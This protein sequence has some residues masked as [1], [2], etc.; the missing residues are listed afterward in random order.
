MSEGLTAQLAIKVVGIWFPISAFVA[1]GF[2]HIPA[3]MFMIPLGLLAG[4]DVTVLEMLYKNFL[5]TTLGNAIAGSLIV[6]GGYSYAFGR[7]GNNNASPLPM[8]RIS[9][10]DLEDYKPKGGYDPE[11]QM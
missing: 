10:E 7:L 6:A 11:V 1:I 8:S 9:R 3:N 5:P 4:A 2:E